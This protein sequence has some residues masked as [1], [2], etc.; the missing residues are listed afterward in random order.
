MSLP[1]SGRIA[2]VY[3]LPEGAMGIRAQAE[4]MTKD[5]RQ[6]GVL[7]ERVARDNLRTDMPCVWVWTYGYDMDIHGPAACI[8]YADHNST[9]P[10]T[11]WTDP[12]I[13][14]LWYYTNISKPVEG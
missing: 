14:A 5:P 3:R 8:S 2:A 10:A 13:I 7:G 11:E 9:T 6:L 1:L 4:A 12:Q